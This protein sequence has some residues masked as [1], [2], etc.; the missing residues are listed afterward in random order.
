[1]PTIVLDPGHGGYDPGA[2]NGK[3][4]EADIVLK[5]GLQLRDELKRHGFR[6]VM[7][8]ESDVSPS[9][10][11]V[12]S[13]ELAA[14]SRIANQAGADF[15]LSLHVNAGGGRG[16]E[17]FVYKDGGKARPLAQKIVDGVAGIVGGYHGTAVKDGS[18]LY[19]VKNTQAP[20]ALLE[21]G[22]IDSD[23]LPKILA[24]IDKFAPVIA[25]SVCA[26]FGIAY[27]AKSAPAAPTPAPKAEQKPQ[28]DLPNVPEWAKEAVQKA[29]KKGAVTDPVGDATFYRLL[30]VLDKLGVL[31]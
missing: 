14:R 24:N 21:I 5:I 25:R 11:A 22:F 13:N 18:G 31:G 26:H 27:V 30:V 17:V 8:R 2:V 15:F 19:V 4:R 16:A 12:K 10:D 29:V 20:A 23:D 9:G 28:T 1:M 7:T 3:T 6:V